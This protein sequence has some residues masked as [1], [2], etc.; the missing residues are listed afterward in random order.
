M[1]PKKL[2]DHSVYGLNQRNTKECFAPYK[3]DIIVK[4]HE[5]VKKNA[6][7][8]ALLGISIMLNLVL[9]TAT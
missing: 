7:K 8:F 3:K 1:I 6:N 9:I 2:Q 4:K 5:F